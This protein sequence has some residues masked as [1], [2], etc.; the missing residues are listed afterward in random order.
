MIGK[1]FRRLRYIGL[2]FRPRVWRW[3][4][5]K[6]DYAVSDH[7]V[8]WSELRAGSPCD[9]HPSVSFRH[10]RNVVVGNHTRIQPNAIVWASPK[11][12]IIIGDYTGVGPG[13]KLFTANHRFEPGTPYHKQPWTERDIRIG[14]DVWIG[15][16]VIVLSGVTIGDGC[17]VAA[18][19]VVNRDIP[20]GSIAAGV[21]ARVIRDR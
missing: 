2:L 11:A 17:V 10:A 3:I 1:I 12:Q 6:V 15:A 5:S 14:R 4:V 16:G 13:A 8:P 19:S 7:V 18:G 20:A 9:I 21:P